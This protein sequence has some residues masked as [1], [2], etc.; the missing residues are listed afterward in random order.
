M[1][2][3]P[4]GS[5]KLFV[6]DKGNLYFGTDVIPVDYTHLKINLFFSDGLD[7]LNRKGVKIC[8]WPVLLQCPVFR[9]SLR[10]N[11]GEIYEFVNFENLIPNKKRSTKNLHT[12]LS[13]SPEMITN[14]ISR[15]II[16]NVSDDLTDVYRR[17]K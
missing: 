7:L 9:A 1:C 12:D 3:S 14:N 4:E 13:L 6:I 17:K 2:F 11:V 5:E 16:T 15:K 10:F 8:N